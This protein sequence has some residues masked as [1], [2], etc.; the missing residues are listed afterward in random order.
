MR[1]CATAVPRGLASNKSI[2]DAQPLI[3]SANMMDGILAEITFCRKSL[4]L[5]RVRSLRKVLIFLEIPSKKLYRLT[6]QI[7][8]LSGG[9]PQYCHELRDRSSSTTSKGCFISRK[10]NSS[11]QI[12]D[13]NLKRDRSASSP[14][15]AMFC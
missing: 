4:S 2:V 8:P 14:P 15:V 12:V 3:G 13:L 7:K 11:S 6:N 9:F 1:I 5:R 10:C